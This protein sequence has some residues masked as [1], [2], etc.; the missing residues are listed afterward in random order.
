MRIA[1]FWK[2]SCAGTGLRRFAEHRIEGLSDAYSAG[3]PGMISDEQVSD[4]AKRRLETTPMDAN[5]RLIR[6]VAE[7]LGLSHITP[8]TPLGC[9][10]TARRGFLDALKE[11]NRTVPGACIS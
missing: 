3:R 7:E 10:R 5:H 1:V 9:S 8:G 11:V 4:M 6:P 2:R